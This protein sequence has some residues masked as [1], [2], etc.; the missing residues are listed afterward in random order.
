MDRVQLRVYSTTRW[1]SCQNR[2]LKLS[3]L[4]LGGMNHGY[5]MS[6]EFE[7][8][9]A[10]PELQIGA[11]AVGE[12][13]ISWARGAIGMRLLRASSLTQPNWQGVAGSEGTNRIAVATGT[14]AAFFRLVKP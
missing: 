14:G 11:G 1:K 8:P 9:Y 12:L 7:C 13:E 6:M 2:E 4:I 3:G 10:E 5:D